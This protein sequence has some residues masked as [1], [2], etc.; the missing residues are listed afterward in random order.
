MSARNSVLIIA[1]GINIDKDYSNTLALSQ[2]EIQALCVSRALYN[3]SDYSFLRTE[4]RIK[5]QAP[6]SQLFNANYCVIVNQ[7]Q[8][9]FFF[10]DEVKYIAD[11]TT[12]ILVT[13]DV[14]TTYKHVGF[15]NAYIERQHTQDDSVKNF[16]QEKI[17]FDRY[18]CN[19]R[20][21]LDVSPT[22][23][24]LQYSEGPYSQSGG[25]FLPPN[26]DQLP[27]DQRASYK[28]VGLAAGIPSML[29]TP[30]FP[31]SASGVNAAVTN[32]FENF[33]KQGHGSSLLGVTTAYTTT[34]P[35]LRVSFNFVSTL[36]GY[37]PKNNKCLQYPYYYINFTNS[38]GQSD[39]LKPELFQSGSAS[40]E[41]VSISVGQPVSMCYP[42]GYNNISEGYNHSITIDYPSI[43]MPVDSYSNSLG[44]RNS[45]VM[46]GIVG[47]AITGGLGLITGNPLAVGVGVAQA[48][49]SSLSS[50]G[51]KPDNQGD[52]VVGSATANLLNLA[53]DNFMF[54]VEHYTLTAQDAKR[55]DDF[56]TAYGYAQNEIQPV[57]TTNPRFHC[58][59]VKTL[60]GEGVVEGIPHAK[61]DIINK[62][63]S[64]GITFWDDND[65][66]G[67]YNT[68]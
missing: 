56:F 34:Q 18:V 19:T 28:D 22:R 41:R 17:N 50:V 24:L 11:S 15:K 42:V 8:R 63:F 40:F 1:S 65:N 26:S 46:S 35:R 48:A 37:R 64:S 33:V 44:Q 4:D 55:L 30:N 9:Q 16:A 67:N 51:F 54:S 52:G 68:K 32:Y 39:I 49:A 61:A 58:H 12:E 23:L 14:L 21:H 60:A 5:V 36:D 7:G 20:N 59:H 29:Y 3:G 66:V 57:N 38:R 43:P 47:S 27:D 31:L 13:E 6:F 45:E 53:I 25:E 62:A 10:V 2:G